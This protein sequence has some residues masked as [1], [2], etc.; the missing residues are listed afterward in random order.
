MEKNKKI[1][2][3][4]ATEDIV[5]FETEWFNTDDLLQDV[6]DLDHDIELE[7]RVGNSYTQFNYKGT[8]KAGEVYKKI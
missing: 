3:V 7:E 2:V 6:N 1:K 4:Y 5:E 8:A